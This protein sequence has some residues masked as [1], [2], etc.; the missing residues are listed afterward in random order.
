MFSFLIMHPTLLFDFPALKSLNKTKENSKS[1]DILL[2]FFSFAEILYEIK[3]SK[4]WQQYYNLNR[5][6]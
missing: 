1:L 6:Q 3:L 5:Y 2:N 4:W